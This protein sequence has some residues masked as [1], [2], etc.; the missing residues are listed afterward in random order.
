[1]RGVL[2][3]VVVGESVGETI[4]IEDFGDLAEGVVADFLIGVGGIGIAEGGIDLVLIQDGFDIAGIIILIGKDSA[5]GIF[6]SGQL[7]GEVIVERGLPFKGSDG[8]D[9]RGFP[10]Q[11]VIL[12][13]VGE[14]G[15]AAV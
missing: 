8:E 4:A 12:I 1:M 9:F 11:G 5:I 2:V 10:A 14:E 3:L 7:S 15:F 6:Q 13:E